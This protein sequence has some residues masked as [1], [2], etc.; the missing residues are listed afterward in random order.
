MINRGQKWCHGAEKALFARRYKTI[1]KT[2]DYLFRG[3]W[4]LSA[5]DMDGFSVETG[6]G[7]KSP[8]YFIYIR[9]EKD[10]G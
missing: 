7:T 10:Y 5:R 8:T 1:D 4:D 2:I 6:L 3:S 9:K